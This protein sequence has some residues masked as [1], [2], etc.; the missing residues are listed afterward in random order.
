MQR[1][2]C[3]RTLHA[4][5]QTEVRQRSKQIGQDSKLEKNLTSDLITLSLLIPVTRT[6]SPEELTCQVQARQLTVTRTKI[7]KTHSLSPN[8][9]STVT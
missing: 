7:V 3:T 1:G 2:N 9:V 4:S 5:S 8:C 6:D